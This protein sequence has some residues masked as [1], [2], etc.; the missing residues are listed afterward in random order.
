MTLTLND[1][2]LHYRLT[3]ANN[4]EKDGYDIYGEKAVANLT[5][6]LRQEESLAKL[7]DVANWYQ[8][9]HPNNR[10]LKGEV[11]FAAVVLAMAVYALGDE[12]DAQTRAAIDGFLINSDIESMYPSENHYLLY[13]T[14]QYLAAQKH[15]E[16]Y[17]PLAKM[18]GA[19]LRDQDEELLCAFLEHRARYGWGEFDSLSY[20]SPDLECVYA[21]YNWSDSPRLRKLCGQTINVLLLNYAVSSVKGY[22]GGA[23]GRTYP[24]VLMDGRKSLMYA[25][26]RLYFHGGQGMPPNMDIKLPVLLSDFRPDPAVASAVAASADM[27]YELLERRHLHNVLDIQPTGTILGSIRKYAYHTPAAV[28]GC[29]VQQDDYPDDR[30]VSWYAH[31]QQHEIDITTAHPNGRV[32]SHH[33][34]RLG[35]QGNNHWSGDMDCGCGA[36]FAHENALMALYDIKPTRLY[37]CVALHAHK[38]ANAVYKKGRRLYLA[39]QGVY[40][41]LTASQ[42]ILSVDEGEYKDVEFRVDAPLC[43]VCYEVF[44]A[45]D[46]A[47]FDDFILRVP[48]DGMRF[49]AGRKACEYTT[50]ARRVLR[51]TRSGDKHVDG[52]RQ[53]FE[54]PTI[55]CPVLHSA[56]GSGVYEVRGARSA[57]FDLTLWRGQSAR[58]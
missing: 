7:R 13:R 26:Q 1:W 30:A 46:F 43:A 4:A 27:T 11:D 52:E 8:L 54:Y 10:P 38:T 55:S 45:A 22:T 36:F 56:W 9:P 51:L 29:I 25:L 49:D 15:P 39:G 44:P 5:L 28:M 47:D 12:L 40:I 23:H 2:L 53:S 32:F 18:P 42:D 41:L 6:G 35:L 21:L 34:G 33:P 24:P 58:T 31:H 3:L 14:A 20:I 57:T 37:Q 48:A 17:F 16:A 50:S 19:Q